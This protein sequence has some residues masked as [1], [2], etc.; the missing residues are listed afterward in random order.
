MRLET[1]ST[2]P[3][4]EAPLPL[5]WLRGPGRGIVPRY[6]GDWAS[7]RWIFPSGVGR[8]AHFLSTDFTDF[9]RLERIAGNGFGAQIERIK[10]ALNYQIFVVPKR[11]IARGILSLRSGQIYGLEYRNGN[12]SSMSPNKS[13]KQIRKDPFRLATIPV[14]ALSL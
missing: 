14:H 2:P 10:P 5:L 7:P 8:L 3:E 13:S 6:E 4:A 11:R 1:K 9:H 12:L